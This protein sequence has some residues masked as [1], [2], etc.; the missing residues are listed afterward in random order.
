[1][2]RETLRKVRHYFQAGQPY[3]RRDPAWAPPMPGFIGAY[4][5]CF[6]DRVDEGHYHTFDEDGL[7]L[8]KGGPRDTREYLVTRMCGYALAAHARHLSTPSD[9]MARGT[10]L[11]TAT[12]LLAM[13][14]ARQDVGLLVFSRLG[15]GKILGSPSAMNQ[16]EA[17][18]IWIRAHSLDGDDR[19]LNAVRQA[20]LPFQVEVDQGGVRGWQSR[21]G[22]PWY[23]EYAER[24]LRHVLNGM[25]YSLIG[26]GEAALYTGDETANRLFSQ[27]CQS[28]ATCLPLFDAGFWSYYRVPED[29][30]SWYMASMMY[31]NLH[32]CQ[33]RILGDMAQITGLQQSATKWESQGNSVWCRLLAAITISAHKA[34]RRHHKPNQE[35]SLTKENS[36]VA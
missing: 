32:T 24:P 29:D 21:T 5:L 7:P 11:R 28:V 2:K 6:Q 34:L 20:L 23:E 36:P 10:V 31:H 14:Q 3:W 1:M 17:I 4:P 30:N 26:L 8:L 22:V 16:G 13:S 19:W 9:D 33:L 15:D 12:K 25:C 18:S 27:G 35:A